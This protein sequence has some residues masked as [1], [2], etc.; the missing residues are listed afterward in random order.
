[1]S[2]LI[3]LRGAP[4]PHNLS[5]RYSV[6]RKSNPKASEIHSWV[7]LSASGGPDQTWIPA[8]DPPHNTAPFHYLHSLPVASGSLTQPCSRQ[9]RVSKGS[10][11]VVRRD[12]MTHCHP[13]LHSHFGARLQDIHA[14]HTISLGSL[15]V[16]CRPMCMVRIDFGLR[17]LTFRY[18]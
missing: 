3:L 14:L 15:G 11:R 7:V 8:I 12:Q 13:R 6:W 18:P 2:K 5:R 16:S 10:F 1:M 9:P 17:T 4:R